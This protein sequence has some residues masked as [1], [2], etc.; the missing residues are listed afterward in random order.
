MDKA[1]YANGFE[2][3]IIGV[4]HQYNTELVVYDYDKC[5]AILI[6]DGMTKDDASEWMAVNVIGAWVGKHTPVFV[7]VG[8]KS[9]DIDNL[10]TVRGLFND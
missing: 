6:R 10:G 9:F 7:Y 3:A 1:L 2:D 5:I 4:G 8:K